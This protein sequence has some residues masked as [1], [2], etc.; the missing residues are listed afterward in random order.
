M[1]WMEGVSCWPR[2]AVGG[3][4]IMT[5]PSGCYVLNLIGPFRLSAP[6][7]ARV[8][9]PSKKAIAIIAMLAT[10]RNGEHTRGWLQ[11]RLWGTRDHAQAQGSLRREL[12]NLRTWL[13]GE[14]S[15][16]IACEHDRVRLELH[17]M[18]VDVHNCGIGGRPPFGAAR[19]PTGEFLEGI[20][21]PGEEGFEEW[22][23]EQ[24]RRFEE[25]ETT[26]ANGDEVPLGSRRVSA[27]PLPARIVDLSEPATGFDGR[28]AL[29]VLPFRNLTGQPELD[30][31]A[32]GLSEDLIIRLSRLRWLPV[33]A[34]SSSFSVGPDPVD[35]HAIGS[36]LG[37]KYLLEGRLRRDGDRF[38]VMLDLADADFA[39]ILWSHKEEMAS[40]LSEEA[41]VQLAVDLVGA[42]DARIDNLEQIRA[43]TKVQS[44]LNVSDLIWRGRWHF[45][46]LTRE[47]SLRA[48]ALFDEAL[49]REPESVEALIQV[50]WAMERSLWA[51]R[52]PQ[53][54]I[55][56]MRRLT[57]KIISLDSDD[58]RGYMLAGIAELWLRNPVRAKNLLTHAIALNPSL[59]GA[60]ANLGSTYNL[61]GQP[62]LAIEPLKTALRLSPVDQEVFFM[63][64]EL[65]MS[66]SLQGEWA[67]AI[68]YAE[69]SLSR[70][71]AY[72]Y[73]HVLKID[74]LA[75]SGKPKAAY[76]AL[77]DL[78][79]VEPAFSE[80]HID[81][82][83]FYDPI[84]AAHFKQG[85]AL[86][87]AG[88][89]AARGRKQ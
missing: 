67:E 75:R 47:D 1:V 36:R 83:P 30:Y 10:S 57:Q 82:V 22:L 31:L 85:I 7:G 29:A 50:A 11:D 54:E 61:C 14:S 25:A 37:A 4:G 76:L 33:I 2:G 77:Q 19:P 44:D 79:S 80:K 70:K 63:L 9:I 39:R 18:R 40:V 32:E 71:S 42:L 58:S 78:L 69:Q 48:R 12:S 51:Q 68:E 45:N 23:R 56:E 41:Q 49:A 81:W 35:H 13:G 5:D 74:A 73:A 43:R 6:D 64:G 65:A 52:G 89:G 21:I 16:L 15:H 88:S 59:A 53:A 84:S 34:R 60:R 86:A 46:R 55:R 72:W 27:A 24:R 8:E 26:G 38:S 17:C 66:H 3:I 20:D 28:S 87:A 62:A